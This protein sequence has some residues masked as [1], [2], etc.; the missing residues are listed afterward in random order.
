MTARPAVV[1]SANSNFG[2]RKASTPSSSKAV[3]MLGKAGSLTGTGMSTLIAG[4]WNV[5][6]ELPAS[7]PVSRSQAKSPT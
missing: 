3:R 6:S 7:H 4:N 2:P 5:G 1:S